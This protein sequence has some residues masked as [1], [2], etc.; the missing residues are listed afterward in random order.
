MLTAG[1]RAAPF[2]DLAE[3]ATTAGAD[4]G[5]GIQRA[6]LFAGRGWPFLQS[7]LKNKAARPTR[8]VWAI[9]E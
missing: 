9:R 1:G 7:T 5:A 3:C 6:N 2:G 8:S 4:T